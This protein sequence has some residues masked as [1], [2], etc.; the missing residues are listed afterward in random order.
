MKFVESTYFRVLP[1]HTHH[2]WPRTS[3]TTT[4]R[5]NL[6]TCTRNHSAS[7]I[8]RPPKAGPEFRLASTGSDQLP[9]TK[10]EAP[11]LDDLRARGREVSAFSAG[12][13]GRVGRVGRLMGRAEV[14]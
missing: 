12:S 8:V 10:L 13:V 9:N 7:V 1:R 5:K 6:K 14:R 11:Q 3:K 4:A 2:H